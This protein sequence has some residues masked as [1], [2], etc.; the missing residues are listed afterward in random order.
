M[1]KTHRKILILI[2]V[3]VALIAGAVFTQ[4]PW[5]QERRLERD[6]YAV[7]DDVEQEK[8]SPEYVRREYGVVVDPKTLALDVS[9]TEKMRA[10]MGAS[11][12]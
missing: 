8:L 11:K 12:T 6:M 4:A 2:M 9:A 7:A 3:T 10:E 1:F 5:A